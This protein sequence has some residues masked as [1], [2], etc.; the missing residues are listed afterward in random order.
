MNKTNRAVIRIRKM[1]E[2]YRAMNE[3]EKKANLGTESKER[4]IILKAQ[5]AVDAAIGELYAINSEAAREA[6]H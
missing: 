4:A 6:R 5:D 2:A 1:E 3:A